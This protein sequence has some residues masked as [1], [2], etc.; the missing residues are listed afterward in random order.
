MTAITKAC[1][2][3][4]YAALTARVDSRIGDDLRRYS[5]G[6]M[7]PDEAA[8]LRDRIAYMRE[9]TAL[10]LTGDEFD[11]AWEMM[12]TVTGTYDDHSLDRET[13]LGRLADILCDE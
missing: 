10:A 8:A 3:A 12:L 5:R 7:E 11:I 2:A 13:Y 6:R 9:T 4:T 1:A